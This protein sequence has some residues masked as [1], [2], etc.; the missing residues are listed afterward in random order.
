MATPRRSRKPPDSTPANSASPN[1]AT[2]PETNQLQPLIDALKAARSGDFTARVPADL[3]EVAIL[4]NEWISENQAFADQLVH[5]S[6]TVGVEGQLHERLIIAQTTSA[7]TTPIQSVNSLID[8]LVQPTLEAEQVF[9]AIAQGNLTQKMVLQVNGTPLQGRLLQVGTIVNGTVD[10]LNRFASEVTRVVREI[11][12]EGKLGI[13]VTVE[14]VAGIWKD[15]VDNMNLMS[16]ELAEQVNSVA[17]IALAVSQRDLSTQIEAKNAGEF[18]ALTESVN[19]MIT[20]LRDSMRQMADVAT[21]TASSSEELT[22]ISQEMTAT[23]TQTAEQ[24]TSAS[25]SAEQVSQN[26]STVA[27]AT[28]EMTASIREIAKTAATSAEVARSAVTT[29]DTTNG[30]MTKLGQSSV[31][32]GKVIKVITSIAQQTNLLALNATIEAARAG[33]AGRGFAVVASEVKELAKQT[34][35]ATEDISQRI[36]SIQADTQ[37]ALR[38]ISDITLIINQINDL[39]TTIASSV[40]EQ[41]AT[42]KEIARNVAEAAKGSSDIAKN[43]GIV[44]TDAQSTLSG[45][46]NMSQAADE[47]SRMAANLQKAVNQFRY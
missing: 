12:T 1:G 20:N 7:W 2:A 18:K 32:I 4:F 33:D 26:A 16:S 34:A 14:A 19:Q 21:V 22:A 36:E 40:E 45:A 8:Q 25:A 11:G 41:T 23:A 27:T 47:L 5:V 15:L 31:E 10:Q 13:Q 30:I 29:A 35:T 43:I 42:T 28:E 38:A 24:A 39:Q 17:K 3:G 37:T 46:S 6:Q 9:Q 44:A